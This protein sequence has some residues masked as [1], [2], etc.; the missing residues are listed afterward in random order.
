M[1]ESKFTIGEAVN[2]G[3]NKTKENAG[4]LIVV[5]L[6]TMAVGGFGTLFSR[7][8]AAVY[9]INLVVWVVGLFIGIGVIKIML[10]IYDGQKPELNLLW[11]GGPVFVNYLLG[12]ILVSLIVLGGL[13]LLVIP[14]IIWSIKYSMTTYL[15]VDKGMGPTEALRKSG[16]ITQ[17]SKWQLFLLGLVLALINMAGAL[18]FVI[19]LLFTIP[20]NNLAMAFVYRKLLGQAPASAPTPTPTPAAPTN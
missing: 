20:L 10:K 13:I 2:F 19:G 11:S 4:L 12:S 6:I 14:G 3:W 7:S 16:E 17:G 18:V 8:G 5:V 9:F 15:I 1:S